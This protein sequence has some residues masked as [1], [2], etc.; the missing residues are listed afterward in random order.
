[1]NRTHDRTAA[2]PGDDYGLTAQLRIIPLLDRSIE[3]V[4]VDMGNFSHTRKRNLSDCSR[5][6]SNTSVTR[7][8][9]ETSALA[10]H[11][12]CCRRI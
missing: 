8:C 2:A 10:F 4:H 6:G 12:A 7:N 3:R 11:A 5:R 9:P 1:M